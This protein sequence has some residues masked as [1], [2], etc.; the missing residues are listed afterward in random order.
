MPRI[1]IVV[2]MIM[3]C[4][5]LTG[6]NGARE[7][8]ELAYVLLVGVD[9][10]KEDKLE[11]TFQIAIPRSFGG[12]GAPKDIKEATALISVKA[13]SFAE[14]RDLAN[15][16]VSRYLTL[17]HVKAFIVGEKIAREGIAKTLPALP[18]FREYRGSM[19]LMTVREGTAKEFIES[20]KPQLEVSPSRYIE[21]MMN[22]SDQSSNFLSS[23]IHDYFTS[24]KSCCA[25]PYL[26]LVG[27]TKSQAKEKKSTEKGAIDKTGEYL[28]GSTERTANPADFIGVAVFNN[29]KLAGYLNN[30]QTR[31]L[32]FVQGK[33]GRGFFVVADPLEPK[34]A[35]NL[36]VE[37]GRNPK[38]E[39]N[40]VN[41]RAVFKIDIMVEAEITAIGSGIN[42]ESKEYRELLE[43][44]LTTVVKADVED[45]LKVTQSLGSDAAGLGYYIRPKLRYYN[46]LKKLDWHDMYQNAEI[47][48]VVNS[49]VR[50]TGFMMRTSPNEMQQ[51]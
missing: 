41:G 14:A 16:S 46:D 26:T 38:I 33:F 22:A 28:A 23:T 4:I 50:R 29:D 5:T 2:L 9:R 34:M 8:D 45:M 17:S 51:E 3:L 1:A 49:K 42:Y 24:L 47:Q 11:F 13:D 18:R 7:S 19:F 40:I 27:I 12:E 44:Q 21:T 39:A 20:N 31:G 43:Q 30:K 48:V 15:S 6:C 25:D 10:D 35:V 32:T 36:E 37:Q